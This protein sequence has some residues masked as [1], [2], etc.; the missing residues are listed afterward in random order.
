[1]TTTLT[2]NVLDK[3]DAGSGDEMNHYANAARTKTLCGIPITKDS[4]KIPI[5][6]ATDWCIVCYE[7]DKILPLSV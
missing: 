3:I 4:V 7:L 2:D 1:M 6:E 5:E